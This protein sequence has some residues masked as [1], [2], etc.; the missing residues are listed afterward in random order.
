MAPESAEAEDVDGSPEPAPVDAYEYDWYRV[1]K[2]LSAEAG[3][4]QRAPWPRASKA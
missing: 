2:R 4:E 1:L 3:F